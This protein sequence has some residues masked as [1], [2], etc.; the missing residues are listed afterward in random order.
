MLLALLEEAERRKRESDA[1]SV[2]KREDARWTSEDHPRGEQKRTGA[3]AKGYRNI[4]SEW[5]QRRDGI[6]GR[7]I[8]KVDAGSVARKKTPR[9]VPGGPHPVETVQRLKARGIILL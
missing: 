8:R 2:R 3:A 5:N 9:D 4:V 7:W 6:G 1:M